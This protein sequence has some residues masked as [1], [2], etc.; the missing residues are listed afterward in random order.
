MGTAGVDNG[1]GGRQSMGLGYCFQDSGAGGSFIR[2][3]DVCA[4]PLH[5]TGPGKFPAQG[6]QENYEETAKLMR[7]WGIEVPTSRDINGGV[8]V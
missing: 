3:R 5:G 7:E 1:T 2:V 4:D 6:R 8:R